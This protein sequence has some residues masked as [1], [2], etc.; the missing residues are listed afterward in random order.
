ML[1]ADSISVRRFGEVTVAVVS[2]GVLSGWDPYFEPEQAW[3]T[4]NTDVE[5]GGAAVGGLNWIVVR[6][7][8]AVVLVDPATFEPGEVIGRATLHA[9]IDLDSALEQLELT[10]EQV[11]HVVVSHFHPDHV[12]GLVARGAT[13]PRFPNATHIVPARD[14]ETFVVTDEGGVA[15]ELMHQLGPVQSAGLLRMVAGDVQATDEIS[16]LD[17]PG[18]SLGH[19]CVRIDTS[20][21]RVYYLADLV[22]FPVEFE[23][24]DWFAVRGRVTGDLIGSRRRVFGEVDDTATLVPSGM[25]GVELQFQLP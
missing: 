19:T 13:Q 2:A 20:A 18:E 7:K 15:D 23:H 25:C 12:C 1:D 16:V 11:T 8:D 3:V 17:A 21:G 4:S 14:W 10:P 9:G 5:P 6:A 22:H 24:I